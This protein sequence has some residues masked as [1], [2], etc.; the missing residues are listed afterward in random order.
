MRK[1][2]RVTLDVYIDMGAPIDD[3][4]DV[5]TCGEW[6]HGAEWA[7]KRGLARTARAKGVE[8]VKCDVLPGGSVNFRLSHGPG[9]R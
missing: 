1:Y 7:I 9:K 4:P 6:M 2:V 5:G 3:L 8:S